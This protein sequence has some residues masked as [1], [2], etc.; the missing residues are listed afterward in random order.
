MA[1]LGK[2]MAGSRVRLAPFGEA[3]VEP[4]RAACAEDPDIW[5]IYPVSMVGTHFD[6]S[7]RFLRALPGWTMFAVLD[8]HGNEGAAGRLVGMTSYIPVPGTDDAIEIG[9]TYI[10]P[11]VRGGPF[12]AEMKRLMIERAFAG[13]Y[14]A[15]QFRIDTRNTRSRRAVEKLGA[16]LVEVRAADLTTWTGYVRDTA[17]YRLEK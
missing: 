16:E 9:A 10:V 4:L 6:P 13:G 17:V 12:N 11:G 15:I 3:H 1:M 7:L 14:A 8:G 2:P 5:E